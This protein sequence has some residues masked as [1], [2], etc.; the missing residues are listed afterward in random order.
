MATST[1]IKLGLQ[2][3]LLAG[4]ITL[5]V[6]SI[7]DASIL[8][9]QSNAKDTQERPNVL[10]IAV[11]DLN[12]WTGHLAGHPQARTPNIDRLVARGVTFTNAHCAAPACNPSRAALMSGLRPWET[13][14]YTN[15][16]PAQG[17]LRNTLTINRHFLANG[18][19]VKGGGKIYHNFAAEGRD[20]TWSEWVGL[21]PTA[22]GNV[23]NLNGSIKSA[24]SEVR[25][26]N[27]VGADNQTFCSAMNI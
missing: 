24:G 17:V 27:E 1:R 6:G 11:D 26:A 25:L 22:G 16:N 23:H 2:R 19:K 21:F 12:D 8:D 10:F 18:Y 9:A 14:I 3:T 7:L 15:G 20:D 4:A 5:C 13:G